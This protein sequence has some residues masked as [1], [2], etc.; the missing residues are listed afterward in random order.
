VRDGKTEH[1]LV[2][3]HAESG[4]PLRKLFFCNSTLYIQYLVL[5][6]YLSGLSLL[7][8]SLLVA[9]CDGRELGLVMQAFVHVYVRVSVFPLIYAVK[10]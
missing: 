3:S 1:K 10:R 4:K 5:L 6:C 8:R 2:K 9:F 7:S